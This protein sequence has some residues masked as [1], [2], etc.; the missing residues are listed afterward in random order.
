MAS[1]PPERLSSVSVNG[2]APPV[3]PKAG[4]YQK[5]EKKIKSAFAVKDYN[6][7]L[8]IIQCWKI[9]PQEVGAL[10]IDPTQN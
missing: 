7:N 5:K 1:A 10:H 4:C 6:I 3:L 2:G 8:S 9:P